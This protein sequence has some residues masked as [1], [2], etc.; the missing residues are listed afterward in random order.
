MALRDVIDRLI[1]LELL[2][3]AADDGA[4][5]GATTA[6]YRNVLKFIKILRPAGI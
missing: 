4:D 6:R 5:V 2:A 1:K 3:P